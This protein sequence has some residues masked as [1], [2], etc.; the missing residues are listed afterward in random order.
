[1]RAV[2]CGPPEP[3]DKGFKTS[4]L[5][6]SAAFSAPITYLR[7]S[8]GR[9]GFKSV[10]IVVG[11]NGASVVLATVANWMV[12][13]KLAPAQFGAFSLAL[14][15]MT[16]GQEISGP[17]LDTAVVRFAT[18]HSQ[19]D[20]L[21]AEAFFKAGF[22]LKLFV[23]LLLSA[24]LA[25][26]AGFL[27]DDV[28]HEPLL[29]PLFY[30]MAAALIF[31]NMSTF[32]LA[33]LQ[34]AEQF[35]SYSVQRAL[36]NALK[37]LLLALAWM[38]GHFSLHTVAAAWTLSFVISY[39]IGVAVFRGPRC[40]PQ[41]APGDRPY[42]DI[43]GFAKWVVLS[44]LFFAVHMR[45]DLLLLGNFRSAA[46]V[47]CYAI[48]WNLMLFMDLITSSILVALL[49]KASKVTARGGSADFMWTTF[50]ASALIAVALSPLYFFS[51]TIIGALF[52]KYVRAIGP[53]RVLFWSSIIVLLIYPLCLSF[54]SQN[55]P[56]KVSLT[57][58]I[59]VLASVGVGIA[60]IPRYGLLG[61]AYTT[62]IA[63]AIGGLVILSF[64]FA[65]RHGRQRAVTDV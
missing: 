31:S 29:R 1:M 14:A 23:T 61:A 36:G 33:R 3:L 44:G 4:N 54:Y 8:L 19:N 28:Y 49:P 17:S 64:L 15:V 46:D 47:G 12:A 9:S 22:R 6:K 65:D 39:V 45:A 10:L 38:A 5:F 11:G 27:A 55:K 52:P 58:G 41:S 30:W 25:L 51:D 18:S 24:G 7:G 57:N 43:A 59:L 37:V 42:R 48:A 63:R 20:P 13:T 53:F 2:T 21:R 16:V 40:R 26:L 62:F 56:A 32:V 35:F 50:T 60:I 34:A